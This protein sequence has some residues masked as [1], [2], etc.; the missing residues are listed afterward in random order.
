[1]FGYQCWGVEGGYYDQH[2]VFLTRRWANYFAKGPSLT[3]PIPPTTNVRHSKSKACRSG[4]SACRAAGNGAPS[5]TSL[6]DP[7]RSGSDDYA[8]ERLT[9]MDHPGKRVF[10]QFMMLGDRNDQLST[11]P[12]Y[13]LDNNRE[14]VALPAT[15]P[16][17]SAD[18][19]DTICPCACDACHR[20]HKR[21]DQD[22]AHPEGKCKRCA[23]AGSQCITTQPNRKRQKKADNRVA[24]L[25]KKMQPHGS[26]NEPIAAKEPSPAST[27]RQD[28]DLDI[29]YAA[30][31]THLNDNKLFLGPHSQEACSRLLDHLHS[32]LQHGQEP[33]FRHVYAALNTAIQHTGIASLPA[34]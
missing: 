33:I 18:N 9:H 23:K 5:G 28:V 27:S 22:P 14:Q 7:S 12:S 31:K 11:P 8:L 10:D 13:Q 29:V 24:E 16:H 2:V 25:E 6:L 1:M 4:F 26:S 19:E 3:L 21:C 34:M 20:L 15:P 30:A 17:Q 32:C